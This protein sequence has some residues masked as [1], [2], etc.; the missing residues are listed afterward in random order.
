MIQVQK[1]AN[2]VTG[3]VKWWM[4]NAQINS[5]LTMQPAVSTENKIAPQTN[6]NGIQ[7]QTTAKANAFQ[8]PIRQPG[9]GSNNGKEQKSSNNDSSNK[10]NF[11]Q[12]IKN[13]FS[14]NDKDP[15]ITNEDRQQAQQLSQDIDEKIG[16][17]FK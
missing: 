1:N 12:H 17:N 13:I 8:T 11:S 6:V 15:T 16:I 2:R 4:A 9:G 5:Y 3:T 10:G 7:Q 14:K